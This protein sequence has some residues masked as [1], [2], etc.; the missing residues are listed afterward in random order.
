MNGEGKSPDELMRIIVQCAI[1]KLYTP[2]HSV[3]LADADVDG[4]RRRRMSS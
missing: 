4:P 1:S 2:S 3:F